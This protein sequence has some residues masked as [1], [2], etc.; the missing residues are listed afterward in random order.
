MLVWLNCFNKQFNIRGLGYRVRLSDN[1]IWNIFSIP[2]YDACYLQFLLMRIGSTIDICQP[3]QKNIYVKIY[4][5]QRKLVFYGAE[6]SKLI[7]FM[8]EIYKYKKP[9]IYTGR[10]IR[11]KYCKPVIKLGKKDKQKSRFY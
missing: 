8:Y 10:G 7:R 1:K 2:C 4:K 6:K 3:L 11:W 5:K 9:N